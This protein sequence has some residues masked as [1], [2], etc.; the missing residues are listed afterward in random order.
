MI[1]FRVISYELWVGLDETELEVIRHK[2]DKRKHIDGK[3]TVGR[4]SVSIK[5]P[6]APFPMAIFVSFTGGSGAENMVFA[7]YGCNSQ[8]NQAIDMS[9]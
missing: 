1:D 8:S 3:R 2:M 6:I 7:I 9:E 5:E 4:I